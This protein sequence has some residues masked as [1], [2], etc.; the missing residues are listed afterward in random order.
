MGIPSDGKELSIR[1]RI[2]LDLPGVQ[3][4]QMGTMEIIGQWQSL[5]ARSEC[6]N[7]CMHWNKIKHF[8]FGIANLRDQDHHANHLEGHTKEM[9]FQRVA[10]LALYWVKEFL[11]HEYC[12]GAND[13]HYFF[14][15]KQ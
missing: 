14:I 7:P 4:P 15:V 1:V 13:A 11:R 3:S 2:A 6:E 10:T 12:S 9:L 5:C 8:M